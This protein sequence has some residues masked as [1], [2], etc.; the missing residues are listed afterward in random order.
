MESTFQKLTNKEQVIVLALP[1]EANVIRTL[2]S[3][4]DLETETSVQKSMASVIE[5]YLFTC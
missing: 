3:Y 1:I 5:R 2:A 4:L